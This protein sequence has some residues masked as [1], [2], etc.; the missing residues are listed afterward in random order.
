MLFNQYMK[1]VLHL[2]EELLKKNN[3]LPLIFPLKILIKKK[4]GDRQV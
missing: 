2:T 3:I 1:Y 4:Y